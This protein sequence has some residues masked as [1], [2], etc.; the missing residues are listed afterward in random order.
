VSLH[1]ALIQWTSPQGMRADFKDLISQPHLPAMVD[2]VC[3][4]VHFQTDPLFVNELPRLAVA[5]AQQGFAN[6][7]REAAVLSLL[8]LPRWN[9]SFTDEQVQQLL[10]DLLVVLPDQLPQSMKSHRALILNKFNASIVMRM[11]CAPGVVHDIY[12][13]IQQL[14]AKY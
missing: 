1:D 9:P 11:S 14:V 12:K 6:A 10:V 4:R 13:E 2:Y 8:N 7:A 3:N 5:L